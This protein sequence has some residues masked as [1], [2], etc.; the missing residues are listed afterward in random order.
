MDV[1]LLKPYMVN[2]GYRVDYYQIW[3]IRLCFV[4]RLITRFSEQEQDQIQGQ[5]SLPKVLDDAK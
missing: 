3:Y 5:T 4:S 2:G 1:G